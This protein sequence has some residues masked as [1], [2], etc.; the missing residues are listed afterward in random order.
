MVCALTARQWRSLA[1]A[2]GLGERFAA[3]ERE[4]GADPKD[5]GERFRHRRESSALVEPWVAGRSLA[6][7]GA[8]LDAAGVLWGPYRTFKQVV[9]EAPEVARPELP[10]PRIGADTE[11]VLRDELGLDAGAVAELRRNGVI[12]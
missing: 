4:H 6:E 7:V 8:A 5:E 11:A 9:E 12:E 1:E 3:T 2:T 10:A